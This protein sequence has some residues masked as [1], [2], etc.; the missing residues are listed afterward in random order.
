LIP[1][2]V[3]EDGW[4]P[5]RRDGSGDVAVL[6][7]QGSLRDAAGVWQHR[8]RVYGYPRGHER[9]GVWAHGVIVGLGE[10]EWVQ[11]QADSAQGFGLRQ[12]FSGAPVWDDQLGAVVGIVVGVDREVDVRTG[13]GI[14]VEAIRRY[15]RR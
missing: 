15:C 4:H 14:P 1:A 9:H 6:V 7:L 12:G 5:Q 11:L 2:V 3:V 13:Y 8:F 10:V